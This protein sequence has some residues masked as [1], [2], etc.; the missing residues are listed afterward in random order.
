MKRPTFYLRD[1]LWLVLVVGMGLGWWLDQERIRREAR[2]LQAVPVKSAEA[3]L[4]VAEAELAQMVTSSKTTFCG[5][6]SEMRRYQLNVEVAKAELE[7]A[8]ARHVYFPSP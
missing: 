1:L 6:V 3:N 7:T 8:R 2:G 4:R 5:P